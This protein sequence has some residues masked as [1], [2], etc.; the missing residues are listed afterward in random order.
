MPQHRIPPN[1]II[2]LI[3]VGCNMLPSE[4]VSELRGRR[5]GSAIAPEMA[6]KASS[7]IAGFIASPVAITHGSNGIPCYT[8][9]LSMYL[10][11]GAHRHGI[12]LLPLGH[13]STGTASHTVP[14][15]PRQ[16][17]SGSRR[18]QAQALAE[19]S[20][21]PFSVGNVDRNAAGG[22]C[23]DCVLRGPEPWHR[24]GLRSPSGRHQ[25]LPGAAQG[26]SRF[27]TVPQVW[28]Q[29]PES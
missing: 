28:L 25:G 13:L 16:A 2:M 1:I 21:I 11:I 19:S 6:T 4:M 14:T 9:E 7:R 26:V 23:V 3:G 18:I 27:P 5:S 12:L 29:N 24:G 20:Q 15:G 8:T 22:R 17:A 10:V